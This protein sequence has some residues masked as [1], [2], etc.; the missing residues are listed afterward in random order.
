MNPNVKRYHDIKTRAKA[1]GQSIRL[2]ARER[3][4]AGTSLWNWDK[5]NFE[6]K[7][8]KLDLI[9]DELTKHE[10]RALRALLERFGSADL[11]L[12]IAARAPAVAAMLNQNEPAPGGHLATASG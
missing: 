6:P 11:I 1:I 2:L 12:L 10:I 4:I 3:G 9:D 7:N 8:S 5:K